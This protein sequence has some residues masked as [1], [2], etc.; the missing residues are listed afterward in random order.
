MIQIYRYRAPGGTRAE[1]GI[2]AQVPA[3]MVIGRVLAGCMLL[4]F[5]AAAQQP[6]EEIW[7]AKFQAT[8][9][10]QSKQP[11]DALYSG[12]HSLAAEREKSYSF[13]A[14]AA[15]GYRPWAGT[16]LYFDPEVAQGV[17]LSGLTGLGGLSNG[18]IARTAGSTPTF[19]RA[20]LFLRQTWGFGGA[21]DT[22]ESAAN[23]LAGAVDRRRIVLT[24]GNLAVADLFD[25]NAYSHDPR[26]QFLNWALMANGAYDYAADARGYS[27]GAV[28]EYFDG[29]WAVRGGRFLEPKLPNQQQLDQRFFEHFG[30]QAELE[31]AH[32][33]GGQAGKIRLLVFRDRAQMA[34]YDDAL[35]L[36]AQSGGTPD[37]GEVR[38]TERNK[39]GVGVS[40]EQKIDADIGLF[41]RAS[42]SDGRT[43]TYAFSEIDR[44]VSGGVSVAGSSWHR[45]RDTFGAAL[46][47]NDLSAAH[48]NYLAAGGLGFFL[49]DGRLN[50]AAEQILESYYSI[51]LLKGMWV[52]LDWQHIRNPGYNADRGPVGIGSARVHAEF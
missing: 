32:T 15:F 42:R 40:L 22:V 24:V 6:A 11:F 17:P 1:I 3:L 26:T 30:D 29:D 27:W 45:P 39:T 9:V 46:V 50:Y 41:A 52:T 23:Q 5:A 14:T 4:P 36:S 35:A 38:S 31:H 44:S 51:G 28:L 10:W 37:L 20:R 19:Y 7:N 34:R 49:G 18:E 25:N 2:A 16:E 48:R 8:Y 13:T 43:E 12:P 33:L 47:R 21:Q